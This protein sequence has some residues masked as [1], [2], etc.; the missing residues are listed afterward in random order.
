VKHA[1]AR[2]AIFREKKA[3]GAI[4]ALPGKTVAA[5]ASY[6][7]SS[8]RAYSLFVASSCLITGFSDK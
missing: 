1:A 8:A 2:F 6:A 5:A 7:H 3:G 4:S